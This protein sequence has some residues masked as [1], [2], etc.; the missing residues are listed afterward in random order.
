MLSVFSLQ[1]GLVEI[2][3]LT[4]WWHWESPVKTVLALAGT[5]GFTAT[6]YV[7]VVSKK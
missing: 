6:C 4:G 3:K 1:E 2:V 5:Q 7:V